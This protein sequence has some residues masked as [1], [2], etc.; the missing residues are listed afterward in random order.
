[1]S[2]RTT[3]VAFEREFYRTKQFGET[4]IA[5]VSDLELHEQ[6]NPQQNSIAVIVQHLHANMM[7]RF[8]NFLETDGEKPAR[9]RDGEFVD[10]GLA[11][12]QLMALWDRGWGLVFDAVAPLG[13]DD[14][15][16]IV[17]IRTEPQTVALAIARQL[18]HYSWHMGK[19]GTVTYFRDQKIGDCP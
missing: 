2:I 10:R 5:Q 1:M 8:T 6:I 19:P 14:L 18:A 15:W 7:S 3:V 9:D 17:T 12:D 11:R 13:D 4:A 16:R